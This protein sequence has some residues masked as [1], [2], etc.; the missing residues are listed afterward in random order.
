MIPVISPSDEIIIS[1]KSNLNVGDIVVFLKKGKLIAHRIICLLKDNIYITKGDNNLISDGKISNSQIIGKVNNIVRKGKNINISHIYM[2]QSV[3]YL[4]ELEK[5]NSLLL[6]NGLDYIL[7][8]GLPLHLYIENE[9]PKRIYYDTDLLVRKS[10]LRKTAKILS[11][12][13]FNKINTLDSV[14]KVSDLTQLNYIKKTKPFSVVI[15]LHTE[16][17]IGLTK[18]KFLNDLIIDIEKFIE[19]LFS[20]KN[21]VNINKTKFTILSDEVLMVYLMLHFFHHNYKGIYR[22]S[23]IFNIINSRRLNWP[24]VFKI[25]KDFNIGFLVYPSFIMLDKYY[26][27]SLISKFNKKIR[28]NLFQIIISKLIVLINSPFN[29]YKRTKSRIVRVMLILLLSPKPL[30]DKI[31]KVFSKEFIRYFFTVISLSF[32]KILRKLSKSF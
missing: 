17:G 3:I 21:K 19:Y 22:L 25:I 30:K 14:G 27:T 23:L 11:S 26:E 20:E 6:K 29:D 31:K 18:V 24:K 7:L 5:I 8:K 15:D 9:I 10:D 1:N 16:P 4:K 28:L 13:G 12:L 2:T 32:N